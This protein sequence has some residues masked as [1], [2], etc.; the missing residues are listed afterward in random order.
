MKAISLPEAFKVDLVSIAE[1]NM[2]K[3]EVLIELRY[4]GLCGSDLNSFRGLSPMVVYPRIPGHEVSGIVVAKGS[5]TP[6]SIHEGQ[7]VTVSPYSNCGKCSA[8]GSGRINACQFNQTLGVQ[9]DGALTERIALR[10]DKVFA[11]SILS[12]QELALVEPLSVGY[13][14]QPRSGDE[15]R[16]C[17]DS[18]LRDHRPAGRRGGRGQGRH[19]HWA[20]R[21]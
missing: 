19:G 14:R 6:F 20:R 8:C 3:D 17:F 10:H 2:G 13:R 9:R 15:Q 16:C 21:G 12:K 5:G 1:P 4:V 11:S 18:R 7:R